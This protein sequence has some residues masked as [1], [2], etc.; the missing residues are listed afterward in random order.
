MK[1]IEFGSEFDWD[2]TLPFLTDYSKGFFDVNNLQRYRSGRD[3]L[4]AIAKF[5]KDRTKT[6]LL[7]ALCCESMVSPFVMNG[8]K[9]VF[10]KTNGDYTANLIDIEA[11]VEKNCLFL[12][13]PYFGIEPVDFILLKRWKERFNII[14]IEDRTQNIQY[15]KDS[16]ADITILSIRKWLSVPDGGFLWSS[17]NFSANLLTESKFLSIRSDAMK[18][19]SEYL[20]SG[21]EEIKIEYRQMLQL[22]AQ[23]LDENSNAYNISSESEEI[24]SHIDFE[25]ILFLRQKNVQVL[26]TLLDPIVKQGKIKYITQN[27]KKSTLYFP[28][29]VNKRDELQKR[30]AEKNIYCP[31]IWP[32]PQEAHGVCEVAEYTANHMLA[33]PCDQRYDQKDMVYIAKILDSLLD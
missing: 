30:L 5:Y 32:V 33:L 10:Y 22:S 26:K 3:A 4:K 8:Y 9:P 15:E 18:K 21:K 7:P 24:L 28:I 2:S 12:Y 23:I 25:K 16:V 19:K 1:I 13:M 11:K 31:V 6:I 27:P 20:L 14:C 29:L 17:E